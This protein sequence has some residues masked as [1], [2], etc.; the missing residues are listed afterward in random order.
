MFFNRRISDSLYWRLQLT[1]HLVSAKRHLLQIVF[2]HF[3]QFMPEKRSSGSGFEENEH[4]LVFG[5]EKF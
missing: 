2:K 3:K 4:I 1:Q 5:I